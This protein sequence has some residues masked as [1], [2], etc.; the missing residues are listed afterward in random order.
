M[1]HRSRQSTDK[2]ALL[3]V[4]DLHSSFFTEDGEVKA[5]NGVNLKVYRGEVFGLVGESGCGKS[6]TGL[7][8]L[9]LIDKPGE[10]VDVLNYDTI[11]I[12]LHAPLRYKVIKNFPALIR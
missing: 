2:T 5:V 11:R 9:R 1:N 10:I 7:S 8:I 3:Q 12:Y 6:V 4:Q